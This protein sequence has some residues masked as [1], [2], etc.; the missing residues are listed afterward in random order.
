MACLGDPSTKFCFCHYVSF[1]FANFSFPFVFAR[2]HNLLW[3]CMH[4]LHLVLFPRWQQGRFVAAVS[5][6]SHSVAAA[7]MVCTHTKH[8]RSSIRMPCLVFRVGVCSRK[9]VFVIFAFQ[10]TIHSYFHSSSSS[11]RLHICFLPSPRGRVCAFCFV[12]TPTPH[13]PTRPARGTTK[14]NSTRSVASFRPTK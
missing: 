6:Q 3:L 11:F 4:G 2:T 1:R 12:F 14:T 13:P 10:R 5:H 7:S 8:E 9:L